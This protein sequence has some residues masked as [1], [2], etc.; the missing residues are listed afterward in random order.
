MK[1]NILNANVITLE[2]EIEA[3]KTRLSE[4]LARIEKSDASFNSTW[5]FYKEKIL[6]GEERDFKKLE[7]QLDNISQE[8]RRDKALVDA[9]K[10]K[11][12]ELEKN[13]LIARQKRNELFNNLAVSWL[14]REVDKF[15]ESALRVNV[16][17]KRLLAAFDLLRKSDGSEI[18]RNTVGEGFSFIPSMKV[19]PLK[20]F[21]RNTLMA[22][23]GLSLAV[24]DEVFTEITK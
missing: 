13:L 7:S 14:S 18:Y 19:L 9:L 1:F 20:N 17:K 2:K 3:E 6:A 5:D 16:A 24:I 11:I 22:S 10:G 12:P 8:T 23:E 21:D 4:T 15:D